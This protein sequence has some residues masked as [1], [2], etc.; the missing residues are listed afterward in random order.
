MEIKNNKETEIFAAFFAL[1]MNAVLLV[2]LIRMLFN[3]QSIVVSGVQYIL[4]TLVALYA[5]YKIL[6]SKHVD[7]KAFYLVV[8]FVLTASL[9]YIVCPAI[10]PAFSFFTPFF[11]L[12][13]IPGMFFCFNLTIDRLQLLFKHM[14]R[15]RLLWV[16]YALVANWYIP[17]HTVSWNQYSMTFGYNL[18]IPYGVIF[19]SLVSERKIKYL[20]YLAVISFFAVLRGSRGV[21]VC[22]IIFSIYYYISYYKS[23]ISGRK[24]GRI[25][26]IGTV[27]VICILFSDQLIKVA[28]N[29][30]PNSRTIHY[31]S[32]DFLN[33]SGRGNLTELV[34]G[35][36]A[37]KPLRFRGFFAD[38][39][40]LSK[41][42]GLI[43]DITSY[44]HNVFWEIF[45]QFGVPLGIIV[46][47]IIIAM[48]NKA[49]KKIRLLQDNNAVCL[50][51][52]LFV[53]G[54]VK[55]LF[56]GSYL[57][58]VESYLWIGF[59]LGI[60]NITSDDKT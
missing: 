13:V 57:T 4:Y 16:I 44:P 41:Y 50:M 12:R 6:T 9:S 53:S 7:K 25:I 20:L 10:K 17:L 38:R 15:Y 5:Y 24:I 31:L 48:S 43:F 33:D 11:I 19:S 30:F 27:L 37:E 58:F 59:T 22:C 35:E 3:R 28:E 26:F 40:L 8:F 49:I 23:N 32:S 34:K 18:L 45:Y 54:F 14:L 46:F 39:V 1:F 21:V 55:L 29:I 60:N 2:D 36:L 51:G 42:E 56:S 52:I 47:L